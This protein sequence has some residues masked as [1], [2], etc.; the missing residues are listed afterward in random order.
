MIII[1]QTGKILI[2]IKSQHLKSYRSGTHHF[3]ISMWLVQYIQQC[4]TS[5]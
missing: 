5:S 2:K 4:V 1:L 3:S